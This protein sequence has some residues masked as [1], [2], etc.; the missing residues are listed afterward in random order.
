MPSLDV[1]R[2]VYE[3]SSD[4]VLRK[5]RVEVAVKLLHTVVVGNAVE[6]SLCDPLCRR[7]GLV[8]VGALEHADMPE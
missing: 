4:D 8:Q 2:Q 6:L 5:D 3:D 7:K 1:L